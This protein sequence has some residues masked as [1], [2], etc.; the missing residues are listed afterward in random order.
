NAHTA[1]YFPQRQR[2]PSLDF[3]GLPNL[4]AADQGQ[5]NG[6]LAEV[7]TGSAG[8]WPAESTGLGWAHPWGTHDGGMVSG[9]EIVLYE[10]INT[11]CAASTA[12][13][14]LHQVMHRMYSDR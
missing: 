12:G 4:R 1:R 13:Y 7:A 3:M 10:G 8:N 11:A 6:R 2:L 5:L 14:R 9:E